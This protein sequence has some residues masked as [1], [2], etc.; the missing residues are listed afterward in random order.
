MDNKATALST[1]AKA[2]VNVMADRISINISKDKAIKPKANIQDKMIGNIKIDKDREIL[3]REIAMV[4]KVIII[5]VIAQE[6]NMEDTEKISIKKVT[7]SLSIKRILSKTNK[8][9]P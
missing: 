1:T 3:K 5:E 2:K 6:D 7:L 8:K 9:Q 4:D